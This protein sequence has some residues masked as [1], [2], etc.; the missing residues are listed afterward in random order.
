[1]IAGGSELVCHGP[2]K[3]M[4]HRV[5]ALPRAKR[6]EPQGHLW[7]QMDTAHWRITSSL[8]TG[9]LTGLGGG[10]GKLQEPVPHRVRL[11]IRQYRPIPVSM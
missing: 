4:D 5:D 9:A 1:M 6:G 10:H 8:H 7:C 2:I 3:G 11:T